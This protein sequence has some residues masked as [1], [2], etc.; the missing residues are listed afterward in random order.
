[1]LFLL[2][3]VS[4]AECS[5]FCA[6]TTFSFF[7][8]GVTLGCRPNLLG[9]SPQTPARNFVPCTLSPLRG[10]E[11]RFPVKQNRDE[12]PRPFASTFTIH[13]LFIST[14]SL[15]IFPSV[16]SV[17]TPPYFSAISL[18]DLNPKPCPVP[19]FVVTGIPSTM[20]SSSSKKFST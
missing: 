9:A 3:P 1:M 14:V 8:M 12:S 19:L 7:K 2:E 4:I 18:I 10:I 17:T 6:E 11:L 20:T 13:C 5:A 16:F 15:K